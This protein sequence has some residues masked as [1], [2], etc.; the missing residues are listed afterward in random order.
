[1]KTPSLIRTKGAQRE[2]LVLWKGWPLEDA[3][4]V[5]Q[6]DVTP[7]IYVMYLKY[8]NL[9]TSLWGDFC[10]KVCCALSQ[11]LLMRRDAA[12]NIMWSYCV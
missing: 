4:W 7:Y 2:F 6:K 5:N 9:I 8:D 11:L 12:M 3:S 10:S 1:M